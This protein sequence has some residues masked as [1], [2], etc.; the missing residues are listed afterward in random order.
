MSST[1][2]NQDR[3][4]NDAPEAAVAVAQPAPP[5]DGQQCRFCGWYIQPRDNYCAGCGRKRA[6]ALWRAS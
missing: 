2:K 4:K 6:M 5:K 3:T 1:E